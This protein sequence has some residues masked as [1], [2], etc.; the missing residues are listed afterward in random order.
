MSGKGRSVY[1]KPALRLEIKKKGEV[2]GSCRYSRIIE[3]GKEPGGDDHDKRHGCNEQNTAGER[4]AEKNEFCDADNKTDEDHVAKISEPPD[5]CDDAEKFVEME[6]CAK[7]LFLCEFYDTHHS[8]HHR[9]DQKNGRDNDRND[10]QIG[11]IIHRTKH[12]YRGY[13]RVGDHVDEEDDQCED[14]L[15]KHLAPVVQGKFSPA[16]DPHH[17]SVDED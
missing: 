7:T 14:T 3:I 15:D 8:N 6:R 9:D 5:P 16:V 13:N 11:R 1:G 2:F 12:R 10:D 4:D 17:K